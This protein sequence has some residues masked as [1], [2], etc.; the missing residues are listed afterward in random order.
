[1]IQ[2]VA[3]A[4]NRKPYNNEQGYVASRHN[5][6]NNGWV[7]IYRLAAGYEVACKLHGTTTT[8]SSLPKARPFLKVPSFC[9][10]CMNSQP[11]TVVAEPLA[12]SATVD[13]EGY[14]YD[15]A[16]NVTGNSGYVT[17]QGLATVYTSKE[18]G[19]D[20][21]TPRTY[22]VVCEPHGHFKGTNDLA[23][24]SQLLTNTAT[25][26]PYCKKLAK[27]KK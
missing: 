6:V 7:V 17:H 3:P 2:P 18:A 5:E 22:S 27:N 1:M 13:A 20:Y 4:N 21:R 23:Q 12:L 14:E 25:F 15:T 10:A 19:I 11:A 24:A 9:A 26:C 8:A 16:T